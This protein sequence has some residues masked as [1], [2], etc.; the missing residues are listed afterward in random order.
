MLERNE[1]RWIWGW[2]AIILVL[3]TLPYVIGFSQQ[4]VHWRFTGFVF[5]VEDGNSYIAKMLSGAAGEWLFRTP[6]SA[7][8]QKG[9]LAF[10]PY[11]L[12]G[13]LT[14]LPG[15]HVQMAALFQVF[16]WVAVI[17]CLFATYDFLAIFLKEVR[18]RRWG[19]ALATLGGG[20]GWLLALTGSPVGLGALPLE[21]YSPETFGFLAL[22]GLP[23]LA[24]ARALFLWGLR[25]FLVRGQAREDESKGQRVWRLCEPGILWLVMGFLQPVDV[26]IAWLVVGLYLVI[27]WI[28]WRKNESKADWMLDF[29]RAM[30]AGVLSAPVLIY[31][32][33]SYLTDPFLKIWSAQNIL[34]SP[35]FWQYLLAYGVILPF[36]VIGAI[37]LLR[38]RRMES[39][40]LIGWVAVLPVLAYLPVTIQRRL[41]EG[42][43]VALLAL[44]LAGFDMKKVHPGWQR[45]F[46]PLFTGALLLV[47]GGGMA[48]FKPAMPMFRPAEEVRAFEALRQFA[49]PGD[50]VVA[51]FDTSNALP[52]WAPLR[53]VI[54]HGPESVNLKNNQT[55]IESMY[56]GRLPAEERESFIREQGVRFL[57]WGPLEKK[58]GEWNPQEDPNLHP[59]YAEDGYTIFR[60]GN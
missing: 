7:V 13:K 53:V 30:A 57:W 25:G 11:L 1:R 2:A 52:A 21:F 3:T 19:L 27:R 29:R 46:Y 6:Y 36:A 60:V 34:P 22:Y 56:T 18:W 51:S 48:A 47:L 12:L 9:F 58:L 41:P 14:S 39:L 16:R 28:G 24:L 43:W 10:L 32:G 38:S 31:S 45:V 44:G 26:A 4:G 59:V 15:Q 54:G 23:H 35:P 49:E 40:F 55:V 37:S 8:A 20:L 17:L 33:V 5:G 42:G 50:V